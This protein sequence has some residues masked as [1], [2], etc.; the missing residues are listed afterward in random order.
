MSQEAGPN[1]TR[2]RDHTGA[3]DIFEILNLQLRSYQNSRRFQVKRV[4]TFPTD[5][6]G[7]KNEESL[8]VYEVCLHKFEFWFW[9]VEDF[10]RQ[11]NNS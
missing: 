2:W 5:P 1:V 4:A 10:R 6:S 9:C 7:I 11:H 8:F 3:L